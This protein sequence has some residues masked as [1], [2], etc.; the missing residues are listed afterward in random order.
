MVF[1]T[2]PEILTAPLFPEYIVIPAAFKD[3][4]VYEDVYFSF[5]GIVEKSE[6]LIVF[7]DLLMFYQSNLTVIKASF[8]KS[9]TNGIDNFA[10][11]NRSLFRLYNPTVVI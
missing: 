1:S 8:V 2:D 5:I 4:L 10:T 11:A 7:L 6:N 3:A 9:L